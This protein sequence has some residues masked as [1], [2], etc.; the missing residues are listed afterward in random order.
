[1]Y[2]LFYLS[3]MNM[4][5]ELD[6]LFAPQNKSV[7]DFFQVMGLGYLIP[8]YQRDY[9]WDKEHVEQLL[10]DIALGVERLTDSTVA[11]QEIRFLGTIIAV[12]QNPVVNKD[13]KG[14]PTRV[15]MIIDGQQRI[16]TISILTSII[17]KHLLS[18]LASINVSSEIREDV[19]ETVRLWRKKLIHCICF[20]LNMGKPSLKPRILRGG[21]DYWTA[22]GE[23]DDAYHSELAYYQAH[24]INS[25]I[26]CDIN[27]DAKLNFP[28]C[29]G[30][31]FY[32]QN[33]KRI[34]KWI[35]DIVGNAHLNDD[36]SFP[37]ADIILSKIPQELLWH[38]Q[39]PKLEAKIKEYYEGNKTK[40]SSAVCTLIQIVA[41]SYYLLERCCFCVIRPTNED[42]AFDMFQSLNATGTPLTALE[43]FKPIVVNYLKQNNM[44]YGGSIS[45][46][47]YNVVQDFISEPNTAT[48]RTRRTND[49][50]T[51]FFIA[52]NGSKVA[53]HFSAERRALVDSYTK[54]S[55]I[56]DRQ[57]FI[58]KMGDYAKFYQLW[59][60][61][62]GA[63]SFKLNDISDESELISML[64]LFLKGCNHRMAITSLASIYQDVLDEKPLADQNF[65]EIVKATVAFYFLWRASYSNNGLDVAYRTL[66]QDCF[67]SGV[68]INTSTIRD[69]YKRTLTE[70][71]IEREEWK[72]KAALRLKYNNNNDDLVKLALLI[73]STDTIPDPEYQGSLKKGKIG[74]C[75][76]M[77]LKAW[78]SENLKSIEHI[79]PQTNHGMWDPELYNPDSMLVNSLGNLTLLPQDINSSVGN[80]G[81]QEKLLYYKCVGEIDPDELSKIDEKAKSMGINL[82]KSTIELLQGCNYGQ[83][84]KPISVLEYHDTWKV[85]LVKYRTNAMLDIIY[86]KLTSWL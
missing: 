77:R 41:A 31:G 20:D 10:N 64:I 23:I 73:A 18:I 62:D 26:E 80:K 43:T 54:L 4:T 22:D 3:I 84:I 85:A 36:D 6:K 45:E 24:F 86:D 27:E 67:K 63:K 48:Q 75:D 17:I 83:H 40:E 76:Y 74:T 53:T 7:L 42:W 2:E 78:K 57:S 21:S 58:K 70:K 16:I 38:S 30:Q 56:Q 19:K 14:N 34:E 68:H 32:S 65:I 13:P 72:Q 49:F 9:S 59:L 51:S 50:I 71:G 28:T 33:Y 35:K 79:A 44:E 52:Y 69:Y 66:F 11:N 15:D 5:I 82:N 55:K 46:K 29:E 1:M 47:Y 8:E 25:Y 61:Y 39:R 12:A 60:E 37:S 81:F